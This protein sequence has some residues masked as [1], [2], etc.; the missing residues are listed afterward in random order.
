ML[1]CVKR[2]LQM[3]LGQ[4]VSVSSVGLFF[5][6]LRKTDTVGLPEGVRLKESV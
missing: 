4:L 2:K 6:S 3:L 1:T 5:D